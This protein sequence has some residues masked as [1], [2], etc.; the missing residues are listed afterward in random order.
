[1]SSHEVTFTVKFPQNAPATLTPAAMRVLSKKKEGE[2]ASSRSQPSRQFQREDR[3]F[4]KQVPA[5]QTKLVRQ[6][7]VHSDRM[8]L[9]QEEEEDNFAI[10]NR[11]HNFRIHNGDIAPSRLPIKALHTEG[12]VQSN[13]QRIQAD[14]VRR[15]QE[16]RQATVAQSRNHSLPQP[17]TPHNRVPTHSS[18]YFLDFYGFNASLIVGW[19][20]HHMDAEQ[21]RVGDV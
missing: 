1:M 20:I 19:H 11:T 8:L 3:P 7:P 14:N 13:R 12:R 21:W 15:R 9:E 5:R 17:T 10:F 16:Q 2:N 6:P 18:L 4:K